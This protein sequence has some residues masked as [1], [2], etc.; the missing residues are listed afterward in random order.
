MRGFMGVLA[1]MA[2]AGCS[3]PQRYALEGQGAA[4]GA[5][6]TVTVERIEGGTS[7]VT[8]AVD[9]LTPPAR[10]GDSLT[11]YVVWFVSDRQVVMAGHLDY[12]ADRRQ[13]LMHATTPLQAFTLRITAETSLNV[14][15]PSERIVG[16]LRVRRTDT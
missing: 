4:P 11:T 8:V 7:L 16:D 6:G 10:L 12:D 15:S 1:V 3:G 14:T 5:D 13:G 9:H 2:L